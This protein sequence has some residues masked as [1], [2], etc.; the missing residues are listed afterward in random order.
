MWRGYRI[1]FPRNSPLGPSL[2]FSSR[3][4]SFLAILIV[5]NPMIS[6]PSFISIAI[7]YL[8]LGLFIGFV[9]GLVMFLVFTRVEPWPWDFGLSVYPIKIWFYFTEASLRHHWGITEASPRH[10]Q[11]IT[12]AS[13]RHHS[14]ASLWGITKGSLRHHP[15]NTPGSK[16]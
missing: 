2:P 16:K 12:K 7:F 10:H 11:G 15:Q 9:W 3:W 14:E 8:L 1:S 13:P 5:K 4:G 6:I